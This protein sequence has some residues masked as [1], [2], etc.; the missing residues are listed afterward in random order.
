MTDA[1]FNTSNSKIPLNSRAPGDLAQVAKDQLSAFQEAAKNWPLYIDVNDL[2][3]CHRCTRC[4]Q[5]I[6]FGT[7][8]E[9]R[10]YHY[11]EDEIMTLVVAHIRQAHEDQPWK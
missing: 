2:R 8:S 6:W 10:D 11:T 9:G 4:G 1:Y 7:D 5:N 3:A